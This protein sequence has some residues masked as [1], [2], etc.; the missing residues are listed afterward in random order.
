MIHC[1][2]FSLETILLMNSNYFKSINVIY[3]AL[4]AGQLL[5]CMAIIVIT[6]SQASVETI[7]IFSLLAPMVALGSILAAFVLN[8]MRKHRQRK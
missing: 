6:Q 3:Y 7:D 5:F 2:A 1:D 8:N 4:L